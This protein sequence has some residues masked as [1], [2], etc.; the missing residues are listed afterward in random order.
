LTDLENEQRHVEIYSALGVIDGVLDVRG[1][2]RTL[3]YLN[4]ES[5]YLTIRSPVFSNPAVK[6][7]AGPL[8]LDKSSIVFVF[9]TFNFT[10]V[11]LDSDVAGPFAALFV[12]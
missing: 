8:A 5:P 11:R 9:E 1:N 2:I 4:I 3:D 12:A 10:P 7:G 6:F